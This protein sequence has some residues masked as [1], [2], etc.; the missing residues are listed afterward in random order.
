L[1]LTAILP[2]PCLSSSQ[3]DVPRKNTVSDTMQRVRYVSTVSR[4]TPSHLCFP[5]CRDQGVKAREQD[6]LVCRTYD[7]PNY[8]YRTDPSMPWSVNQS[9]VENL[10]T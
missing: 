8:F 4:S 10:C 7:Q 1:Y 9:V 5:A 6:G 2:I 3:W